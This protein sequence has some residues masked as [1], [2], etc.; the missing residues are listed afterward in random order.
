MKEIKALKELQ[1]VP[2][3]YTD[4]Y[5]WMLI[6]L[7]IGQRVSDNLKLS[8]INLRKASFG[9]CIDILQQKQR[10]Q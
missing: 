6:G 10:R 3:V 5:S 8:P 4:S 7:C 9:L 1:Y 2:E